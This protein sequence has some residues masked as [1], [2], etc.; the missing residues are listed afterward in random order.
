MR[1]VGL[2]ASGRESSAGILARENIVRRPGAVHAPVGR[3][4]VDLAVDGE[5][6]GNLG[7]WR[8]TGMACE[9]GRG[10][11]AL[12]RLPPEAY[13]LALRENGNERD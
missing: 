7:V 9:G 8:V 3:H 6:E 12:F 1:Q 5:Q 4:V 2:E 11:G 10:E 13:E